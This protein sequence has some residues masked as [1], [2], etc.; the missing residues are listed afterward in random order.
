MLFREHLIKKIL[1][2]EKTRTIR[3]QGYYKVGHTYAVQRRI[4]ERAVAW[5]R[6]VG[7]KGPKKLGEL[8][9][10]DVRPDGYSSLPE[11]KREWE[12]LYGQWNPDELI[13][14]YDFKVV[15]GPRLRCGA[16]AGI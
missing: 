3:K 11:F 1:R 5:I 12:L 2:G 7:K 4:G 9:D 15:N 8:T 16:A 6:I 14:I 13:W 10:E